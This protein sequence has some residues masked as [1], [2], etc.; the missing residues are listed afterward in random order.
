M[1]KISDIFSG[2]RVFSKRFIKTFPINSKEFEIEAELTIHA[3]EQKTPIKEVEC[4][5]NSRPEGSF[6]KLSTY[7]DGIKFLN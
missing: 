1:E 7:R 3:I 5:Y 2:F 6:S 4:M